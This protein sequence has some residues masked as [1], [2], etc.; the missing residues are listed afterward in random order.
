MANTTTTHAP[1]MFP[2]LQNSFA[3]WLFG[4]L[5]QGL[6]SYAADL[7]PNLAST[8][9]PSVW[10]RWKPEPDDP[11]SQ[12]LMS[13]LSQ[14]MPNELRTMFGNMMEYGGLG[15]PGR[16]MSTA[17][18]FGGSGQP[19]VNMSNISQFG[20]PGPVGQPV[21]DI[22]RTG[23]AGSWGQMLQNMAL[24]QTSPAGLQFLQPLMGAQPWRSPTPALQGGR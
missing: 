18:Q 6:P 20:M 14:G 12:G 1:P 23:G 11:G 5:G 17:Q 24:G 3:Q 22:A 4:N 15:Y 16:M 7:F 8:I 10:N 21:L 19:A 13:L 9:L 2:Q